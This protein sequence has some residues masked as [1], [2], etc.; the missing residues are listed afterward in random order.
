MQVLAN[1]EETY[2]CSGGICD[3]NEVLPIFVF[4]NVNDGLPS[5]S[6]T[7]GLNELII[8]NVDTYLYGFIVP[9]AETVIVAA[10]YTFIVIS[11]LWRKCC[12]K[13]KKE[14]EKEKKKKQGK[15]TNMDD[16]TMSHQ[17]PEIEL[18]LE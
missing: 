7:E 5:K 13:S 10:A 9:L 12:R 4:S 1:I 14:K 16:E 18:E 17:T 6:C 8:S 11:K 15:H 3:A 2:Q